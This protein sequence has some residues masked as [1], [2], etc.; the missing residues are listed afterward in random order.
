MIS[1]PIFK[2][3]ITPQSEDVYYIIFP[4]NNYGSTL[5]DETMVKTL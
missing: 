4:L 2:T 3:G 1:R 5:A